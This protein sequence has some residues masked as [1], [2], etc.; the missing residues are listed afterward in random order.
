MAT[1]STKSTSCCRGKE[2]LQPDVREPRTLTS[3]ARSWQLLPRKMPVR[4]FV[5]FK[6]PDSLAD[7]QRTIMESELQ[8]K[9][10]GSR[11]MRFANR[12]DS[13]LT[14]LVGTYSS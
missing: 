10:A 8:R 6:H 1:T 11:V 2:N 3:P 13:E 14:R 12:G 9:T 5:G 7:G 4:Q